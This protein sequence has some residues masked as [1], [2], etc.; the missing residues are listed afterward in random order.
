MAERSVFEHPKPRVAA[1]ELATLLR[2]DYGLEGPMMPLVS[3]RD[4]NMLV[5]AAGRRCVLKIANAAEDR[6]VLGLQNAMLDHIAATSPALGVP[7]L[8]RTLDGRDMAEWKSGA[9]SHLV[10]VLEHL[11]GRLFSAVPKTP[12][13]LASLGSFMGR[14]SVACKGFGHPL[15]H[16]PGF[17]WNL[18]EALAVKPWLADIGPPEERALASRIFARYETRVVPRLRGLRAGVLHQDANDNNLIVADDGETVT[19]LIDFGD[20]TF[21]RHINELA[22]TLAYALLDLDN[23]YAAAGP[24]IGAYAAAFPLE[25]EEAEVLFDLT[26]TRL[27]VSVCV[28][29]HRGKE[30]PE[31]QYLQVSRA[32]AL[33]LLVALDQTNP[34]LLAA[35][36]RHAAGLAPVADHD[37]ARVP[38]LRSRSS[39]SISTVR[40]AVSSRCSRANPAWSTRTTPTHTGAGSAT[41]WLWRVR[42]SRS[43]RTGRSATCTRATSSARRLPRS[44]ARST[45][46]SISSSSRGRRSMR[47]STAG[48]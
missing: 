41:V 22:V 13:L 8:V 32:A 20:M 25:A 43:A 27:A 46:E 18:D 9:A 21:G 38:A 4:Q 45:S 33:R 39:I 3:E 40:R 31:N 7:R 24:L 11:P 26:A 28:S 19:G 30:F 14:F 44:V 5:D 37:R 12:A 2:R 34:S 35:F 10:R 1:A 23:L 29:S 6:G 47:R 36:A 42:A 48:C 17:L 16:R 15:A